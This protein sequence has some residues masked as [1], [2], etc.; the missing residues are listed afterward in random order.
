MSAACRPPEPGRSQGLRRSRRTHASRASR[1]NGEP[2]LT[3]AE[4]ARRD[5]RASVVPPPGAFLQASAE[6]E[7]IMARAGHRASRRSAARRRPLLPASALSRLALAREAPVQAVESEPGC[8]RR[9]GRC[10]SRRAQGLKRVETERRDLF[11]YP[12]L[13]GRAERLRRRRLRSAAGRRQGAGGGA[14]RVPTCRASRRSPAIRRASRATPASSSTAATRS[15]ASCRS[16]SSS[17]RPRRRW[18]DCS[19]A[20]S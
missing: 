20:P 9:A 4:P 17:T 10:R 8:A 11:A 18:W 1:S 15:S 6:A 2:I 13:A 12:A 5:L 16:T 3:L 7:Q 14:R 19:A